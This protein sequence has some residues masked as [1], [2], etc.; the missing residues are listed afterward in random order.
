MKST[1]LKRLSSHVAHLLPHST[2]RESKSKS[3]RLRGVRPCPLGNRSQS[4]PPPNPPSWA[5]LF[6]CGK[7]M[8]FH[9]VAGRRTPKKSV[10]RCPWK[11]LIHDY[12]WKHLSFRRYCLNYCP[13]VVV[14]FEKIK[15]SHFLL[16][17][18]FSFIKK[19]VSMVTNNFQFD[20]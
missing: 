17:K 11:F 6:H 20:V 10:T 4:H 15:L 5:L 14:I 9:V 3:K 2:Q 8:I 18:E 1:R 13:I 16:L 19:E 7:C 12:S